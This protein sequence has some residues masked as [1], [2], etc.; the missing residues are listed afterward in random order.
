MKRRFNYTKRQKIPRNQVSLAWIEPEISSGPISFYGAI[1]PTVEPPLPPEAEIYIEAYN[2]PLT[3]RFFCGTVENPEIPADNQLTNFPPG[4]RPNFRVKVTLPDDQRKRLLARA[5]S[6]SPTSPEDAK[7]GRITILPV[8]RVDL[9]DEV[10]RL[11]LDDIDAP[12]LQLNSNITEP[13]DIASMASEGDFLALAYPAVIRQILSEVLKSETVM[14]NHPWIS[15]ATN[16]AS[17]HPPDPDEF[18]EDELVREQSEWIEKAV[19][20]FATHNEAKRKFITH[21]LQEQ[22]HA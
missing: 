12:K 11:D 3:M 4:V 8:E 20:G 15:F 22:G 13:R 16:L 21:K 14:E 17:A 5:D 1:D 2:G 19:A 10:W 18:E 9:K 6:V 7:A